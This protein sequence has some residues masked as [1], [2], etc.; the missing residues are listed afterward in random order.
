VSTSVWRSAVY[1]F[2]PGRFETYLNRMVR[3]SFFAE[4]CLLSNWRPPCL[5]HTHGEPLPRQDEQR[6]AGHATA[7]AGVRSFNRAPL[8]LSVRRDLAGLRG[9]LAGSG[10]T[11]P[12]PGPGPRPKVQSAFYF[13]VATKARKH[14]AFSDDF[15]VTCVSVAM[16]LSKT[17]WLRKDPTR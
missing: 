8:P 7:R 1:S 17:L 12:A 13:H 14:G 3:C 10:D 5:F 2:Q 15:S 4:I 16:P 9:E 11:P 6:Q